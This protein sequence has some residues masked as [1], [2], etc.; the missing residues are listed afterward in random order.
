MKKLSLFS[1]ILLF[2]ACTERIDIET[3]NSEPVIVIYG[4]ITDEW[5]PQEIRIT[6]SAPF[7][8]DRPNAGVSGAQVTVT[9]SEG[10]R[11][12]F[13]ERESTPGYY[14]S[15]AWKAEAGKQ[16]S[17]SVRV[18]FDRDGT[19]EH[20][21]ASTTVL[22]PAYLDSVKLAPNRIMGNFTY[23]LLAYGRDAASE[24]YYLFRFAVNGGSVSDRLSRYVVTDDV[25][26]NGQKINGLTL[27]RFDDVSN[28]ENDNPEKRNNSVYLKSGDK[29]DV[30]MSMIRKGYFDFI[31]QCLSEIGRENPMFGAPPSNIVTNISNG[32]IGYFSGYCTTRTST[33][34]P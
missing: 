8:D 10:K 23:L 26:F 30:E 14:Y 22:P 6:R 27:R 16:Y 28:W 11:Y 20:Y 24:D 7:F 32:G 5:K 29:L 17:L 12:E 2:A 18:D 13:S 21:E 4:V 19:A 9:S 25:L 34:V 3:E 31:N 1:L 33:L 15:S